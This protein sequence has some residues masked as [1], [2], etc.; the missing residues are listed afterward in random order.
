MTNRVI[1]QSSA[2]SPLRVSV[3]GADAATAQFGNLIFDGNQPPLRLA[4]NGYLTMTP[5]TD[6]ARNAPTPQTVKESSGVPLSAPATAGTN[7]VFMVMYRSPYDLWTNSPNSP[8]VYT[9]Q[10]GWVTTPARW[11]TNV[12]SIQG[13]LGSGDQGGG[14][15]ILNGNT[16]VGLTFNSQQNDGFHDRFN[17]L[18]INY[19]IFKNYL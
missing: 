19:A 15:A 8:R 7:P 10:P 16:F 12:G 1:I 11:T 13:T 18:Y 6:A 17:T 5:I 4:Q 2:A 9:T 3:A 14:G